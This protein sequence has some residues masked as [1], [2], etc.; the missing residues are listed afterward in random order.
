MAEL[1]KAKI[2]IRN[3]TDLQSVVKIMK[4]ISSANILEYEESVL[5]ISEYNCCV[6][7]A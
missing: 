7:Y 3:A 1:E 2:R 5:S 4:A 6:D